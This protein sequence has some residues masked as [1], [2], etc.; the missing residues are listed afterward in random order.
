MRNLRLATPELIKQ[1]VVR[2]WEACSPQLLLSSD[3]VNILSR[4]LVC[5]KFGILEIEYR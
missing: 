4:Y 1:N 2:T 3:F 5:G